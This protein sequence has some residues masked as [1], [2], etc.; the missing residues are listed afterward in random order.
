MTTKLIDFVGWTCSFIWDC[1]G[2]GHPAMRA[3]G[4]SAVKSM[5][6]R[7]TVF[8]AGA[9]SE[10]NAERDVDEQREKLVNAS[11]WQ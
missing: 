1:P 9:H 4:E 2:L 10:E 3:D 6:Q 5:P 8:G 7:Q 11:F